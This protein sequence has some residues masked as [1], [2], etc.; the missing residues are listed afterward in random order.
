MN[1]SD[2]KFQIYS[3]MYGGKKKTKE[4]QNWNK[5]FISG[6]VAIDTSHMK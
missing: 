5:V 2:F 4:K 6:V 1:K 3:N